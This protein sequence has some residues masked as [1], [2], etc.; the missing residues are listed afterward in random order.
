MNLETIEWSLY[1]SRREA[2]SS[3]ANHNSLARIWLDTEGG[4]NR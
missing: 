2:S 3:A 1:P 4:G